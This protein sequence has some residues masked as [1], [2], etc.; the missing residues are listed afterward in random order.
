MR[1]TS[2]RILI[3]ALALS[4]PAAA[5]PTLM[6]TGMPHVE[7]AVGVGE[8][9]SGPGL[10][11]ERQMQR[12]DLGH[13]IPRFSYPKTTP[14]SLV[15]GVFGQVHVGV[16][17][18]TTL[19]FIASAVETET[20]GRA[21]DQA[22]TVVKANVRS[23]ALVLSFR[24]TPWIKVGAGPAMHRRLLTF[25]DRDATVRSDEA[26]W[27]ANSEVKF[28]R[29][30]ADSMHPARFGL[31]TGQYRNAGHIDV[32]SMPVALYGRERRLIAWPAQRVRAS[33]WMI[34]VGIGVEI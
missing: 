13:D 2:A 17:K 31:I 15:P 22:T 9:L 16:T 4:W 19:G 10:D 21:A 24:P 25:H 34:G 18:H 28:A 7:L 20:S 33:H 5:Q 14:P 6:S 32:P 23:E 11:L 27:L 26:G 12:L 1:V 29:R 3:Y 8:M 30:A